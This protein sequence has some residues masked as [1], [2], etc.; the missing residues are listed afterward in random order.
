MDDILSVLKSIENDFSN[1]WESFETIELFDD[2]FNGF[3]GDHF[4]FQKTSL[5]HLRSLARI[6]KI[7]KNYI[8]WWRKVKKIQAL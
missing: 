5:R 7:K 4:F 6:D 1:S 8:H 2:I 3:N